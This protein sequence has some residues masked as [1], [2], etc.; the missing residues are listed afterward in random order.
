MGLKSRSEGGSR[1]RP[2]FV[3]YIPHRDIEKSSKSCHFRRFRAVKHPE[4][5]GTQERG[6]FLTCP[7]YSI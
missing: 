2:F 1:D 3:S 7:I 4:W 5:H 6:N